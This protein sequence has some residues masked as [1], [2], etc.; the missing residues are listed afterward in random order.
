ME[1][2]ERKERRE[3]NKKKSVRG[4]ELEKPVKDTVWTSVP[5]TSCFRV[6][7]SY[8]FL[9]TSKRCL[10]KITQIQCVEQMSVN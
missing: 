1:G 7:E 2:K 5:T 3:S 6:L 10:R 9:G 4:R 8:T